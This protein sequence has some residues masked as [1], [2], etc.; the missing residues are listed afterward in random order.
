M[1]LRFKVSNFMSIKEEVIVNAVANTASEHEIKT[2]TFGKDRILPSVGFYGYNA[3]GKSNIFKALTSAILF[4]R[5]SNVMQV[6]N[7]I[8][9]TPFL[10]DDYSRKQPTKMDFLY[11]HNGKKFNYGFEITQKEVI[12]EY[13]YE[14]VSSRPS[15][16]FERHKDKYTYTTQNNKELETYENKNTSNKLFLCTAT[17]WNCQ[18]TKDAYLWFAEGVDTYDSRN[19]NEAGYLDYLDEKKDDQK[20]KEFLLS[21]LKHTD[22]NISDYIF[23]SRNV[24]D[25]NVVLPP[26]IMFDKGLIDQMKMNSKEFKLESMHDVEDQ[27]GNRKSFPIDFMME[28]NGTKMMF[29]Y[30]P[31]IQTALEKGRTIVVDEIDNSLH[32]LL[33]KYLIQLFSNREYNKKGAQ[34]IFNFHDSNLLNSELMRR[35]QLY[36][37]KK[38]K[39]GQ[40][41]I[42]NLY[43]YKARRNDNFRKGYFDGKYIDLPNITEGID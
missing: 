31:I 35:D 30:A 38:D 40:T 36:L 17:A 3:A 25:F 6:N 37:V 11:I 29:A 15:L 4:V 7:L 2:I 22:F 8:Q 43:D 34:L 41:R 42:S 12:Q 1:L 32:T 27:E 28:S 14:Y 26:G 23:E 5:N 33:T 39:G 18:L 21:V 10:L 20:T 24:K 19:F 13:L 9:T 16:I